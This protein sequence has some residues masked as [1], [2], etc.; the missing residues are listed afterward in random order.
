MVKL[1]SNMGKSHGRRS[2]E[3]FSP[4]DHKVSDTT[5]ALSTH[6]LSQNLFAFVFND[7]NFIKW[8]KDSAKNSYI[9]LTWWWL[10]HS[11]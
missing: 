6:A 2:L 11:R 5:E 1:F 10:L 8:C 3:G 9:F 7:F 4:W